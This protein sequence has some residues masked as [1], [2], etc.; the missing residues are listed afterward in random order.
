[1]II[2]EGLRYHIVSNLQCK[3]TPYAMWMTLTNLFKN[4]SDHRKFAL[5]EKLKK[6]KMEKG[7]TIPQ[8]L[9]RFTP[10][11]DDLGSIGII[12]V[13]YDLLNLTLLGLPKNKDKSQVLVNGREKL[14]KWEQ[15]WFELVK[16]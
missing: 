16:E 2:L 5:K 4:S 1:M 10:C 7:D 8:Y 13:E 6:I 9:R 11:H 12:V 3:E 14:P 15:L